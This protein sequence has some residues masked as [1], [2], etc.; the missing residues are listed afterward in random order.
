MRPID[1]GM[2]PKDI[3]GNIKKFSKYQDARG[4]L[5]DKLG[6]YCSYCEMQLDASLAVEHVQPKSNPTSSHLALEWENFLL[7]CT[8]CNSIKGDK[9]IQLSEYYWADRDNTARAFEYLKGGIVRVSQNL[10]TSEQK[11]AQKTLELT[12]LNRIPNPDPTVSDRRWSNRRDAWEM[13]E[14]SLYHLKKHDT[15]AMRAQIVLTA[16]AKGFWS[17][18]MTVF[19]NDQDM[20]DRFIKAFP[21]TCLLSFDSQGKPIPRPGGCL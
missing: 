19:K 12:G 14:R 18:W 5:I 13:A 16:Q 17:V 21:G 9:N 3:T 20:L 8:N 2:C 1:R 4:D 7:A 11:C 6:E 10:T 15:L